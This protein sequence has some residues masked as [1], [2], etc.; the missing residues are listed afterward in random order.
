MIWQDLLFKDKMTKE[1]LI[2]VLSEVFIVERSKIIVTGNIDTL[3]ANGVKILCQTYLCRAEYSMKI[4]IYLRDEVALPIN[5]IETVSRMA[6]YLNT[7]I[8]MSHEGLNPFLMKK[9]Q[10]NRT[11]EIVD[12][13]L[14]IYDDC[15]EIEL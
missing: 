10:F 7:T 3:D 11:L 6:E 13:D 2:E 14:S 1:R 8:I 4:S 9:I 12:I 5:D 15:E